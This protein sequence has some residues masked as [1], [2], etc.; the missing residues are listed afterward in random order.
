MDKT[1]EKPDRHDRSTYDDNGDE[2][3][4]SN[5]RN[6]NRAHDSTTDD[7]SPKCIGLT[8][9]HLRFGDMP[10]FFGIGN[11]FADEKSGKSF[12]LVI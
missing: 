12:V 6:A 3:E 7:V 8:E 11:V 10:D 5:Q 2:P 1:D 9:G 4:L